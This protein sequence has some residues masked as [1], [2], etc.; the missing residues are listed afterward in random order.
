MLCSSLLFELIPIN[1]EKSTRWL[2]LESSTTMDSIYESA[3]HLESSL[4]G[5][6]LAALALAVASSSSRTV[7]SLACSG[8]L[9]ASLYRNIA[10]ASCESRTCSIDYYY[11]YACM[12]SR[13]MNDGLFVSL[14]WSLDYYATVAYWPIMNPGKLPLPLPHRINK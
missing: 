13:E 4:H 1:H 8:Q 2:A 14:V 10:A 3:K 11:L 6:S 9:R 12:F 7:I 5:C